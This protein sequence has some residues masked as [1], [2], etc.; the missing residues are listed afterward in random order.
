[1]DRN[2]VANVSD[3]FLRKSSGLVKSAGP[4]D[5]FIYNFSLISVGIAVTLAHFWVPAN[6][7]GAS[8]PLAEVFAGLFM[9]C[10]AF[11]FWCWS[12]AIPRSGGIYAYLSRSLSPGLGFAVSF[13]D[14]F[15]W[16]FY[17]A[18]AA[19]FL[20]TIGI[21]PALFVAGSLSGNRS[22]VDAAV[23]LQNPVVQFVIGTAAICLAA[24]VLITGMRVF[25]KVQKVVLALA[26]LGTVTAIISLATASHERFL[27]NFDAALAPF[28]VS[29]AMIASTSPTTWHFS[30]SATLLAAV[31]PVLSYVGS[32]FSVNIGG[33]VRNS[34]RSQAIGMFGSICVAAA[35]MATLSV[36]GDQVFGREFQ[37]SL[38][39]FSLTRGPEALPVPPYYALLAGLATGSP[40]LAAVICLGF[41]AWAFFW[42]PATIVYA[43]RAVIAWS[44]DRIAPAALGFVH[45]TRHTPVT[46]IIAVA[47]AN[48]LM[49][50]LFLF[51]PFFGTLVLVLAAMLAWIPTMLGAL[52]FPYRR[53]QMFARSE[54]AGRRLLGI[55]W[56]DAIAAGH[57]SKSLTTIGAVFAVGLLWYFFARMFR[58]RQGLA[59]DRAFAEIPIE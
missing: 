30:W 46:A 43:T 44:F 42:I 28:G 5:V 41:F 26:A 56:N 13:V 53:P 1:M 20:V 8:L 7:P 12:V 55:P 40:A 58:T 52:L 22:L 34:A 4:L 6:Y 14:T 59:I 23:A 9:A 29:A 21:G 15:V 47:A 48:I 16:L 35:M 31:W 25:F 11:G 17:N 54:M 10:I 50:A 24:G 33:E 36:L 51:T 18:L 45:P 19:T 32:I 38:T 3:V 57:S 37:S 39:S 2:G 27:A 49:L